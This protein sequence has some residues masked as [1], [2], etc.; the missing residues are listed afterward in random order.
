MFIRKI[1][2]RQVCSVRETKNLKFT[3][4]ILSK[5]Y[6]IKKQECTD[7]NNCHIFLQIFIRPQK[8]IFQSRTNNKTILFCRYRKWPKRMQG[9]TPVLQQ[10]LRLIQLWFMS[11]KV[12]RNNSEENI[13]RK[14][15][16]GQSN[17]NFRR[18]LT[19]FREWMNEW[20]NEK[21]YSLKLYNFYKWQ[22]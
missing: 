4:W 21:F 1:N 3:W 9:T 19:C 14:V 7:K 15:L 17:Q 18:V 6:Q 10:M 22:H 8:M 16:G 12:T 13:F 11:L 20:M 2:D 5:L